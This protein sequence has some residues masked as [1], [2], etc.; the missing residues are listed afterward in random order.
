MLLF[1]FYTSLS[2]FFFNDTATTEIYTLSLHDALPISSHADVYEH[3]TELGSTKQYE[4]A[5]LPFELTVPP[6]ALDLRDR[7]ST[8]LNSSHSSISYAVFCLKK[9]NHN[10]PSA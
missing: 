9:K 8:R 5:T 7:K 6:D 4:S 2:S 1:T 3:D 10:P